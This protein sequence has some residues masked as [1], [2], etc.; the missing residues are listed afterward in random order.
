MFNE[1]TYTI[2]WLVNTGDLIALCSQCNSSSFAFWAFWHF[3]LAKYKILFS[4][5]VVIENMRI[6][7]YNMHSFYSET[8]LNLYFFIGLGICWM[9]NLQ[10]FLCYIRTIFDFSWQ[11][12][13]FYWE[14][15][16]DMLL[17]KWYRKYIWSLSTLFHD[18]ISWIWPDELISRC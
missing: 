16:L 11:I 4:A 15:Y 1:N 9:F 13:S 14:F 12:F 3:Q 18:D 8:S 5:L 2:N 17:C 6:R 10:R 7:C